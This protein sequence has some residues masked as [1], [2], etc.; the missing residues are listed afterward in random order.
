MQ[1]MNS[2]KKDLIKIGKV[3][4]KEAGLFVV[5]VFVLFF[6]VTYFNE[7]VYEFHNVFNIL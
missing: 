4:F 5:A 6:D 2:A 1:L 7:Y 3:F